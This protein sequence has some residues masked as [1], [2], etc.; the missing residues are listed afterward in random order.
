MIESVVIYRRSRSSF[1]LFKDAKFTL[2]PEEWPEN[3]AEHSPAGHSI[4]YPNEFHTRDLD[5]GLGIGELALY[6]ITSDH[7]TDLNNWYTVRIGHHCCQGRAEMLGIEEVDCEGSN[8][9]YEECECR[10]CGNVHEIE[11]E[12]DHSE[13]G[14]E[15]NGEKGWEEMPDTVYLKKISRTHFFNPQYGCGSEWYAQ[16]IKNAFARERMK[17]Q[18]EISL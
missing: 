13:C 10:N 4:N 1:E 18:E 11:T 14:V 3:D 16:E 2:G 5:L 12:S 8:G 7:Q 15:C 9:G 6:E 17:T